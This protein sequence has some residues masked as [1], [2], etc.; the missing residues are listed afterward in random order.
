M[1]EQMSGVLIQR[2]NKC[3]PLAYITGEQMSVYRISLVF[4]KVLVQK[5]RKP[6]RPIPKRLQT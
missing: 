4:A 5:G 3:P 2:V 6:E 1:G